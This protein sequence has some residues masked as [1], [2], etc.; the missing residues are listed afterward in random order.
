MQLSIEKAH[1]LSDWRP[2]SLSLSHTTAMYKSPKAIL[3]M[4]KVCIP[5]IWLPCWWHYSGPSWR[6]WHIYLC[7]H[8][9]LHFDAW[10][11]VSL[12]IPVAIHTCTHMYINTSI[13]LSVYLPPSL[14]IYMYVPIYLPS[15]LCLLYL[16]LLLS[17][18]HIYDVCAMLPSQKNNAKKCLPGLY[19]CLCVPAFTMYNVMSMSNIE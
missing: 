10:I 16:S 3:A 11:Y 19:G 12:N 13:Y 1:S 8:L 4:R 6:W 15:S 7:M 5:M 9:C 17:L 18:S 2:P 14:F